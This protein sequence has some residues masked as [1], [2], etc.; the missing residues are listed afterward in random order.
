MNQNAQAKIKLKDKNK[1]LTFSC[2]LVLQILKL[3][4]TKARAML[5]TE[6]PDY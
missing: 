4:K 5:S 6:L 2:R 1:F 3:V